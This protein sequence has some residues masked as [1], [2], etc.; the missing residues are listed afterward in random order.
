MHDPKTLKGAFTW[1]AFGAAVA[2]LALVIGTFVPG[3]IPA[4]AA[5]VRL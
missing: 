5:G 4:R 1:I 3:I 2:G